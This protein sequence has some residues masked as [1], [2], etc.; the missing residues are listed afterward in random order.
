MPIRPENRHHYRG[1]AWKAVRA[2]ILARAGEVRGACGSIINE[3][4]CEQ[5]WARNRETYE[6]VRINGILWQ[7]MGDR[8]RWSDCD[9]PS[10]CATLALGDAVVHRVRIVL[11]ISHTDHDPANNDP[12]NLRALCQR[13]HNRHDGPHR[14]ETR[15]RT[16][17]AKAVAL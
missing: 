9:C 12:A 15:R 2:G 6:R 8:E 4:S 1:A 11:T 10:A 13:C 5:C 14:A 3:A 17:A 7:R 16:R